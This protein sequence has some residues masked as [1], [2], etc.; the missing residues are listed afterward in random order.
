MNECFEACLKKVLY[1]QKMSVEE[2]ETQNASIVQCLMGKRC[3][4]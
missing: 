2:L 3:T 1:F 4:R